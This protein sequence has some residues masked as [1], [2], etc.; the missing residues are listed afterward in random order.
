MI[1]TPTLLVLGAGA[2]IRYGFPSG[3]GLR[4]KLWALRNITEGTPRFSLFTSNGFTYKAVNEFAERFQASGIDSIDSFVDRQSEYEAIAKLAIAYE[5]CASEHPATLR[6]GNGTDDWY[7]YLWNRMAAGART[8]DDLLKNQVHIVTFNYDRS[9]KA[10]LL[11]AIQN[12]FPN[13]NNKAAFDVLT[14]LPICH[15]Y[16]SVGAVAPIPG[17]SFFPYAHA[18]ANPEDLRPFPAAA[19]TIHLMPGVRDDAPSFQTAQRWFRLSDRVCFLG[20]GFDEL[21]CIRLNFAEVIAESKRWPKVYATVYNMF[22]MEAMH[23]LQA[24]LPGCTYDFDQLADIES[25]LECAAMLRRFGAL[26]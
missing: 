21:N 11:A 19:G 13:V 24:L 18:Q 23:S 3:L 22:R 4:D 7:G 14:K 6:Q 16:G 12:T 10:F 5:I 2:S 9:L 26:Y 1:T 8:P 15:M 17:E 25:K 20:F